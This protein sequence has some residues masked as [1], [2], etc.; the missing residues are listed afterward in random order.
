MLS[1]PARCRNCAHS[2]K[3][4]TY[5]RFIQYWLVYTVSIRVTFL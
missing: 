4:I 1:V 3:L 5:D 2:A